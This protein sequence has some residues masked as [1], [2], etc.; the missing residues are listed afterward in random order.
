ISST[1][2]NVSPLYVSLNFASASV[3]VSAAAAILMNGNV[4]MGGR[5]CV[6]AT[7]R[8]AMPNRKTSPTK[9]P[10]YFSIP[11]QKF[12]KQF[13]P[14]SSKNRPFP[15]LPKRGTPDSQERDPRV[16]TLNKFYFLSPNVSPF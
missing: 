12:A 14:Q 3:R 5:I 1:L 15:S 6:L 8:P 10:S 9:S 11:S 7:P 4:E 16:L 2:A 13:P